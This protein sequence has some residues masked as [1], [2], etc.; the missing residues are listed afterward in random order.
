MSGGRGDSPLHNGTRSF[1]KLDL[2][3]H[4][5]LKMHSTRNQCLMVVFYYFFITCTTDFRGSPTKDPTRR[6]RNSSLL[7]RLLTASFCNVSSSN[8]S[9]ISTAFTLRK[10]LVVVAVHIVHSVCF[11]SPRAPLLSSKPSLFTLLPSRAV[12]IYF[13]LVVCD[14]LRRLLASSALSQAPASPPTLLL[15]FCYYL[16]GIFIL[17]RAF[18]R[19]IEECFSS[20]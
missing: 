18:P 15:P 4:V 16:Y 1:L 13:F 19:L 10:L 3:G 14:I 12:F 11:F 20:R 6:R 8:S 9:S 2:H 7:F 5:P 17:R